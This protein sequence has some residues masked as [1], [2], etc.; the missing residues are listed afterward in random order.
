MQHLHGQGGQ[1]GGVDK[2]WVAKS[3]KP[4]GKQM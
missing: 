2:V 4:E 1:G 3:S